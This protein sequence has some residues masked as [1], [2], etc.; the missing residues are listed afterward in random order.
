VRK[1]PIIAESYTP[2]GVDQGDASIASEI[3]KLYA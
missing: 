3:A 1:A 2:N